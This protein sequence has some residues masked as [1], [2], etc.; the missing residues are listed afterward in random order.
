MDRGEQSPSRSRMASPYD[1]PQ[2]I[3]CTDSERGVAIIPRGPGLGA[4]QFVLKY[5]QNYFE[6]PENPDYTDHA[7]AKSY[8]QNCQIIGEQCMLMP[9]QA[10]KY[11]GHFWKKLI[12]IVTFGGGGGVRGHDVTPLKP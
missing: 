11:Q 9:N 5:A 10:C 3:P 4:S 8:P 2:S 12:V 6:A 1:V 7:S